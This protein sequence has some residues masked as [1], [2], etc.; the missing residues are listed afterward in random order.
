MSFLFSMYMLVVT[1]YCV[2]S[3][4]QCSGWRHNPTDVWF[5]FEPDS[6]RFDRV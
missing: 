6:Y 2:G 1:W 3:S 5:L 4:T